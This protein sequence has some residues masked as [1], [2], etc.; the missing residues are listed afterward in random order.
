MKLPFRKRPPVVGPLEGARARRRAEADLE[1]IKAETPLYQ[2]L[3]AQLR[4]IREENHLAEAL[5]I[6]LRGDRR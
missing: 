3:G 4:Q 6:A 5:T 2:L 1:R